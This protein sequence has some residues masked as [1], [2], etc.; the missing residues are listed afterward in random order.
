MGLPA[1]FRDIIETMATLVKRCS[2]CGKI[3][4]KTSFMRN[5]HTSDGFARRCKKCVNRY[6]AIWRANN[7]E[8]I[9]QK[10]ARWYATHK[11]EA[12]KRNANWHAANP[13]KA[14][15]R[16]AKRDPAKVRAYRSA[17]LKA[18]AGKITAMV[19]MRRAAK[20]RATPPWIDPKELEKVYLCAAKRGLTVDHIIPLRHPLVC[21]LHVP[22][23]LRPLSRSK[24]S[25]KGNTFVIC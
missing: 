11:K 21:G 15:K 25:S 19:S 3:K 23:N 10:D 24:N 1:C 20:C 16:Y 5:K 4:R 9:K 8:K 6:H 22:W 12:S 18:N 2:G 14:R 17:Y 13:A 7:S